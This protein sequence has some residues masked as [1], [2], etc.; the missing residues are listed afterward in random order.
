VWVIITRFPFGS[1]VGV[2]ALVYVATIAK[3]SK[4]GTK[5]LK[6]SFLLI[7][8][9]LPSDFFSLKERTKYQYQRLFLTVSI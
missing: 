9:Y 7:A 5:I 1:A 2:A 8:Q 4:V 3:S 6:N